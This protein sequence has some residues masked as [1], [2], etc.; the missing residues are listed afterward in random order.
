M[1]DEETASRIYHLKGLG[2]VRSAMGSISK[3]GL[4]FVPHVVVGLFFGNIKA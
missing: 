2:V 3:S 1:G 4:Q